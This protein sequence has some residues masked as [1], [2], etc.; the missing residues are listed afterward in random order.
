M[1]FRSNLWISA[2]ALGTLTVPVFA[3]DTPAPPTP[4]V[5]PPTFTRT[6][7]F[8]AV[9][10]ASSESARVAAVNIAP[11][12][13]KG[14]AA[15]CSGNI[16]FTDDKG[17]PAGKA[18]AFTAL[19]TGQIAHGDLPGSTGANVRN[20]F[21]GSVQVTID[22]ASGAPCSLLLTLEVFDTTTGVTHGL[23]TSA[24]EAPINAEPAAFGHGT[25]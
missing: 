21:Q 9:G 16:S 5:T 7:S 8:P 2:V 13:H 25:H 10:L 4:P 15:S 20:E 14:T 23:V 18:T 17:T 24:I 19:G 22:P 1:S 6:F 12:S 3:A 11:A